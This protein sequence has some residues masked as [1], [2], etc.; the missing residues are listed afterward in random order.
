MSQQAKDTRI[1]CHNFQ[2]LVHKLSR[3]GPKSSEVKRSWLPGFLKPVACLMCILCSMRY[4]SVCP[5]C[6][7]HGADAA[8][9]CLRAREATG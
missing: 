1:F 8:L 5:W 7:R 4:K 2:E 3:T 6:L 9:L